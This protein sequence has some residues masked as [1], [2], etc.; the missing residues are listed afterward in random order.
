MLRVRFI[1]KRRSRPR[2][3]HLSSADAGEG[4]NN[5][6]FSRNR[7]ASASYS[8]PVGDLRHPAHVGCDHGGFTACFGGV[9]RDVLPVSPSIILRS[10]LYVTAAALAAGVFV[11]LASFGIEP[12]VAVAI[13]FTMGFGLRALAIVKQLSL[14]SYRGRSGPMRDG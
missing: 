10:E 14:P 4:A 8:P 1:G 5:P 11:V 2:R 13:A 9:F 3:L 6:Q 7:V 12:A